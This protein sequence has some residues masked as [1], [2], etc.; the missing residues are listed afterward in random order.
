MLEAV[1][2][3]ADDL[4]IAQEQEGAALK[5]DITTRVEHMQQEM[6]NIA[7]E[8]KKLIE[9][10]KNTVNE[11]TA[12]VDKENIDPQIATQLS[13]AYAF[14][15]KIDIH[16][17]ITRFNS[18]IESLQE[19]VSSNKIDKGKR[20]DFTLQEL[21]RE[22]NTITA[23]CSDAAISKLAINIKVELEKAREQAQN[24]V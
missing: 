15:D 7:T 4:I 11:L 1:D 10:Q 3:L 21:A 6:S 9:K 24:I 23:K 14:L 12:Q 18:H 19:Q 5:T 16:E 22:I 13:S 2:A 8:S 17:E 20:L